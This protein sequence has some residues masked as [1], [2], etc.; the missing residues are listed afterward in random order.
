MKQPTKAKRANR[1]GKSTRLPRAEAASVAIYFAAFV[2]G[3][4][5]MGFEMLGSRYLA[6]YFG[7]GI[8]TW[9]SLISTVLAALCIGYF[10]GGWIADR[11]PSLQMLGAT[12]IVGSAYLVLLPLFAEALLAFVLERVEDIRTGSLLSALAIMFFP[13]VFLGM[14][15]PFAI[16]LLLQSRQNSGMIAGTVYG[17]STAGSILG[18]LGTTFFLISVIGSRAITTLLG[19]AGVITGVLL[20]AIAYLMLRRSS[21]KAFTAV[22]V[23]GLSIAL[24]AP[25]FAEPAFDSAVRTEMLKRKNGLI[26][27]NETVYNDIFVSREGDYL[28]MSFQWKG[29]HFT[30]SEINLK[31]PDDLPM[32]YARAITIATAYPKDIKRILILGLGGG[33]L[34]GYFSRFMPDAAIDTVELDPGVI[35]AAKKYFGM[36][37]TEKSKLIANDGRVFLTRNPGKYDFIIADAF[38]GSYIPFHLMTKEFY[39]LLR[40]RLSPGGVAAFNIYPGTKLYDAN[41][42]TLTEV[43]GKV[44]VYASGE[45]KGEEEVIAIVSLDRPANDEELKRRAAEIQEKYK[46]RFDI[47]KL[48][49]ERRI[50]FPASAAKGEVLTDDFAPVNLYDSYGR[51]YRKKQ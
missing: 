14:Y 29:F 25:A 35:E 26:E 24:A 18:T 51:R 31:D 32:L 46:F 22:L 7:S 2:T 8:Y 11:Y 10:A 48:V 34:T 40:D 13:V 36:R 38:T 20:V 44:D 4:I 19:A 28:V 45:R 12:V 42:A 37:E 30:E 27:R 5:V 16:R 9:A 23:C 47:T 33:Q 49:A 43:F 21:R 6:P 41:L 50:P 39:R 15:S 3:A 17:I 1:S